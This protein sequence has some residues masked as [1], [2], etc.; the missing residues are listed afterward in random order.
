M[1]TIVTINELKAP[2]YFEK[3][4]SY[5]VGALRIDLKQQ[6]R[7]YVASCPFHQDTT[8]SFYLYNKNGTNRFKCFST[9]CEIGGWDIFALMQDL[10]GCSFIEAVKRFA[11]Y[12]N[13]NEV[14]IPRGKRI[15]I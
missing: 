2:Y 8:P 1:K 10:E 5:S 14:I 13:V 3:T 12:V 6:G 11:Q 7:F 15:V 9:K 4:V